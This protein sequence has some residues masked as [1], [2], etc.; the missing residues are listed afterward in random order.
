MIKSLLAFLVLWSGLSH[1]DGVM[2]EGPRRHNG[3][4]DHLQ[5]DPERDAHYK[6]WID[7]RQEEARRRGYPDNDVDPTQDERSGF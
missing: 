6:D 2:P 5:P 1:A 4:E 3:C 7:E